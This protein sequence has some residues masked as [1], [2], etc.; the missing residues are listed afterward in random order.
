MAKFNL[1]FVGNWGQKPVPLST[2]SPVLDT[3]ESIALETVQ[4]GANAVYSA[5]LQK[6]CIPLNDNWANA[7]PIV[8]AGTFQ[9]E[10]CSS[11]FEDYS[12]N[13]YISSCVNFGGG[14]G[15]IWFKYT[16]STNKTF[17]L[18]LSGGNYPGGTPV[19]N[20][21]LHD[22]GGVSIDNMLMTLTCPNGN[23]PPTDSCNDQ[24][25][26]FDATGN[27]TYWIQVILF[28]PG[29]SATLLKATVTIT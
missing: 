18:D 24:P 3:G 22:A 14:L 11:T 6:K 27:V 19:V 25:F 17:G 5:P 12:G 16:P 21:Y 9:R 15:D 10:I 13:D 26:T 1:E 23:C 7:E 20:V 8:S 29:G 4:Q 28:G 2:S